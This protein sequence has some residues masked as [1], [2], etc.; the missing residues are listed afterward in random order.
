MLCFV[1]PCREW[2]GQCPARLVRA[3][4]ASIT[5]NQGS[6]GSLN[7][8]SSTIDLRCPTQTNKHTVKQNHVVNVRQSC[9]HAVL[10]Q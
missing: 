6:L 5:D 4:T 8:L 7:W 9:L 10:I 2:E 3:A 1:K